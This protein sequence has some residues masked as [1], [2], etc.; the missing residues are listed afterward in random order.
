MKKLFRFLR[1]LTN[2]EQRQLLLHVSYNILLSLEFFIRVPR[3]INTAY[4]SVQKIFKKTNFL[5]TNILEDEERVR[6][7]KERKGKVMLRLW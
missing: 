6:T 4:V 1:D 2:H 5:G 7:Q 3:T